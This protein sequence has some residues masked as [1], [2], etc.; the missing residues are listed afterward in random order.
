MISVY[1]AHNPSPE[2]LPF[3]LYNYD[4]SI[5]E[6][7]SFLRKL[8]LRGVSRSTLRA[9]AYDLLSFYRFMDATKISISM[10][11]HKHVIDYIFM[12]RKI[13]AAPRTINRRIAA[14]RSFLNSY[15][16]NLGDDLFASQ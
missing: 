8:L 15:R 12:L 3:M 13:S 14:I 10:L 16:Q 4:E 11:I 7:T 9:Y 6:V 1:S 5:I 2:D